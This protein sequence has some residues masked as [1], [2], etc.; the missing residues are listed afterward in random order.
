VL[1]RSWQMGTI[2]L[3]AIMPQRFGLTYMGPDNR[4][5][6]PYVVHRA[7]LGSL[8]RF[9]GILIEHYAGAFPFWLAPVQIRV[10]PVG[11]GHLAAA[12]ALI[13]KL[14]E[15]GYRV[16]LGEPTETIGK[17]IREAELEKVPFIV[18]FGDRESDESL[19]IRERGGGQSQESLADFLAKLATLAA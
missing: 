2:Q 14:K 3:D 5:H 17:R 6:T 15:P 19:A 4:E 9:L 16:D 11:E 18:V 12:T 10:L 7:L 13:E 8:E 1:G